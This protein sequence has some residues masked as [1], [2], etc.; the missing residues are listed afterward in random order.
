MLF[1]LAK[2]SLIRSGDAGAGPVL[3]HY[4]G[5]GG[6]GDRIV[7]EAILYFL[8][9]AFPSC[10]HL[11]VYPERFGEYCAADYPP[12]VNRAYEIHLAD[13]K[14]ACTEALARELHRFFAEKL[15]P[16]PVVLLFFGVHPSTVPVDALE[17]LPLE[18]GLRY[19]ETYELLR[20]LAQAGNIYPRFGAV[21]HIPLPGTDAGVQAGMRVAVHCRACA[22]G[23][24]KN[25]DPDLFAEMCRALKTRA[26]ARLFAVGSNDIPPET[27]AVVDTKIPTTPRLDITARYLQTCDVLIGGDSGPGHLA[28]A[29][30]IPVVSIQDADRGWRWGPF[31]PE[32][33]LERIDGWRSQRG[34]VRCVGFDVAAAVDAAVSLAAKK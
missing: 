33:R 20:H 18:T 27:E 5:Q 9:T 34:G 21:A 26:N 17:T 6:M 7:F 1:S 23:T 11:A 24:E 13:V 3:V 15:Q 30:G 8:R 28:A 25:P 19:V 2:E 12:H 4:L 29:L 22:Y 14:H 31:A 32:S 10:T 16:R